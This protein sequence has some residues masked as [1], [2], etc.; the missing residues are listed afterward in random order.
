MRTAVAVGCSSC[1][2]ATGARRRE[3]VAPAGLG[4]VQTP[5]AVAA[6]AGVGFPSGSCCAR[7]EVAESERAA[8]IPNAWI[9]PDLTGCLAIGKPFGI[10][11]ARAQQRHLKVPF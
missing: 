7:I 5:G 8:E 3:V 10:G 1:V 9:K 2:A 6:G 4:S 11:K